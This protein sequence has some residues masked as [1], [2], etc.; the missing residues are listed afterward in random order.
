M[1][2]DL[3]TLRPTYHLNIGLP[4]RSNALL[5]AE[6]L[7][8]PQEIIEAA[9]T[10]LNPDDLRAD[11]M[12]DEIHHQRDLA[13][14]ARGAADRAKFETEKLRASLA[15]RLEKIEDERLALLEK[16]RLQSEEE[17]ESLRAELEELRRALSR[18]R[19][20]LE[21]LK[22]LQERIEDMQETVQAP[23]E[24]R[25]VEKP[26]TNPIRL[27]EKVRVRSLKLDGLVTTLGESDVEVQIGVLRVR[28]RL[29]DIQRGGE[30][31]ESAPVPAPAIEKHGKKV[32]KEAATPFYPSPGME[33]D[34]R[35][36]RAEDALDAL[37]RYLESAFLAG[38]LYVRIIHGKGT[39]R[40]R[41]V[42]REALQ[43]SPHIS[44]WENGH[45]NEGGEGVTI[46][47][48]HSP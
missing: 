30:S 9:R 47:H 22:P 17:V 38:L 37:D 10:T 43:E 46:A 27:G 4:G 34:L 12:L 28:A 32:K 36:Q 48:L 6:R 19:Q 15:A 20:P 31:E 40:L 21:A 2:F 23:V 33:L 39:G 16:A 35:G 29:G 7:G 18:A 26:S 25:Q 42:V 41:Q 1:E 3:R 24:R 44:H 8:L 11:N 14:R 13:R 45:D 5:I